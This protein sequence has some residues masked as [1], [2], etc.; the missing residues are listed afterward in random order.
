MVVGL[1]A[2]S[3]RTAPRAGGKD[4]LEIVAVTDEDDLKRI[5]DAMKAY[6][7]R[8][9]K[10]PFWLRDASN[11]KSSQVLLLVGLGKSGTAGHDCGGGHPTCS[12]FTNQRKVSEKE[13]G[14][15][16]PHCALRMM[17]IGV[18]LASGPRLP[19]R[20]TWTAGSS[21]GWGQRRGRSVSSGRRS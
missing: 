20:S 19:A 5:G 3:A 9:T 4:F 16:G 12:E 17:D 2:A 8:S 1:M 18:A 6:A 14:Y 7:P 21:S 10:E 13:M 11:I 15:T